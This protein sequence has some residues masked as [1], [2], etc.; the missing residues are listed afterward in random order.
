MVQK[1]VADTEVLIELLDI[2]GAGYKG[3]SRKKTPALD[4]KNYAELL[5]KLDEYLKQTLAVFDDK[6]KCV[7]PECKGLGVVFTE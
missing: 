6:K 7:C 5:Q 2:E 4:G 1:T 3:D